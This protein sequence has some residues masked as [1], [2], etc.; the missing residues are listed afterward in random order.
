M[1]RIRFYFLTTSVLLFWVSAGFTQ[2]RMVSG[3]ITSSEGFT[4]P[5]VTVLE[6]GTANATTS[7][8]EGNYSIEVGDSVILIFSSVG[9]VTQE[10]SANILTVNVTLITNT[11]MLSENIETGFGL[12]DKNNITGA[13]TLLKD[14]DFNQGNIYTVT[15]LLQGKV[16][17]ISIYNWGGDPNSSSILRIR[18]LSSFD[19]NASPLVVING[20][21][22]ATLDNIDPNDIESITILKDGSASAIYGIRDSNGVILIQTK[23]GSA[24][25]PSITYNG[26]V[27]ASSMLNQQPA[28]SASEYLAAGGNDQGGITDW[29]D[30]VTQTGVSNTHS[31]AVSGSSQ[32]TSF[33]ISTNLRNINGILQKSGF[34][35]VNSRASLTH[36]TFNDR[37][38][39]E[40]NTAFT[41]R[42]TNFSFNEALNYAVS[43]IPTAPIKHPNGEY[44]QALSFDNYNPVAIIDQNVNQGKKKN[45]NYSVKVDYAL[46]ADLLFTI[47]YGQQFESTSNG[48]Y[49]SRNSFFRGYNRGGLAR[50][51]VSDR[52][53]E[54]FEAYGRYKKKIGKTT[55]DFTAGYSYQEDSYEDM[56]V[57]LGDFPADELGYHALENSADRISGSSSL[58]NIRSN[59]S[60][61]NRIIAVFS[62]LNIAFNNG[63]YLSASVRPEGSSKLGSNNKT[64]IFSSAGVGVNL[65]N[66]FEN[67]KADILKVRLGYGVTGSIP[68]SSGLSHDL[69][70]YSFSGGG[71]TYKQRDGNSDLKW[72]QK[73]ELNLGLDFG[74]AGK[75][76][77]ALELYT[78]SIDDLIQQ[79]TVDVSVYPSGIRF[80]NAASVTSRGFELSLSY[81]SPNH[82][83]LKWNP[84][85]V[86]SSNRTIIE[87]YMSEKDYRGSVGPGCGCVGAIRLNVGN[88]IGEIWGPVFVGVN[89]NGSP[90]LK[91]L[92][93]DGF[94]NPIQDHTALGNG[95]PALEFGFSNQLYFRN[96]D[97]NA[98]F[99]G[100][101]GHSLVN[102]TRIYYESVDPGLINSYNRISTD[103]SVAGLTSSQYSSLYV[104]R[105]DFLKLDNITLGYRL[106]KLTYPGINSLRLYLTIQNA[107]VI[108][109]YS[110][111][112]PEPALVDPGKSI[113][114][115]YLPSTPDP[116]APGID[117]RGIYFP[118]RTYTFGLSIS[119]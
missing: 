3:K 101:I 30:A 107:F 12:L 35:Q 19:P 24:R 81:N 68:L 40:L 106:K 61:D 50:R 102:E 86:I 72:E 87:S 21:A 16:A 112:N 80:E 89:S 7:N 10:V 108:S 58:I 97:I 32:N 104:E 41:N 28:F 73:R 49:Y 114:G 4:I 94:Y 20:V 62:R 69:Y 90:I 99:R 116:L 64:G 111:L 8:T 63:I 14:N 118:A 48:E 38:K 45:I 55:V 36:S 1:G 113:S 98:F 78:R 77:G 33:R 110:G 25:G 75:I 51:F 84:G 91:D 2:G 105:A 29:Q 13:V 27:A 26:Y 83:K 95:L 76:S 60:P 65:L 67:P 74:F 109:N 53:F 79:K 31:I 85:I 119:L 9:Y 43:F 46:S 117:R 22:G 5:G 82:G 115:S 66:Y 88:K 70:V 6:K 39:F 42:N 93:G 92:N 52:S 54:L 57:E 18:S 59:R 11:A 56:L 34:N 37:L 23:R 47:N 103:K 17:G 96:W 44:Y 15:Q 100:A 71:T